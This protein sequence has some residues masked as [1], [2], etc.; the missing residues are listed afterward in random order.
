MNQFIRTQLI[1]WYL[2][3]HRQLPWRE[4]DDPYKIWV[5][6]VMLQQT[7]VKTVV[8]YYIKFLYEFPNLQSLAE[9][10]LQTVLKVW[11]GMGY[12]ARARNL[13]QAAKTVLNEYAGKIPDNIKLFRKLPGVGEYIAA[14]VLSIAFHQ[15]YYVVDGNVKRV[16]ARLFK[17]DAPVNKT[18]SFKIFKDFAD[19]LIDTSNPG[20]FNQAIMELGAIVCKPKNPECNQCPVHSACKAH[21]NGK[22]AQ[23]PKRLSAKK[24]PEYYIAVGIVHKNNKVLITRRKSD[25]LLGGLWEF[26]GGKVMEGEPAN[27]ACIREIKEEAN[28]QVE[29]NYY[30]TRIKHAYTHFKIIMD[31]F[32]CNYI[33]GR[34]RLKGPVDH[35]WVTIQKIDDYPFP[36]ANHKFIPLLK[37][38]ERNCLELI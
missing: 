27:Q 13:H 2:E 18:A 25:G 15:P 5:S 34:V 22:T 9:A 38:S 31:V 33:S 36:K 19:K 28:L 10:N 21:Q 24:I 17:I 4:T 12:Y 32:D 14:A 16:L 11:E 30:L 23:Y 8:P 35:A 1:K 37:K 20:I 3:D 6:E 29:I 7:Q 26:P